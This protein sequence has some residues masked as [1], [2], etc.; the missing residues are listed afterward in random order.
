MSGE[1]FSVEVSDDEN[2]DM[3]FSSASSNICTNSI[4][5]E[6]DVPQ[7]DDDLRDLTEC[8][9]KLWRKKFFPSSKTYT[10]FP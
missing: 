9:L 8:K 4:H 7:Y 6:N 10:Y 1:T 5:E 2:T 3:S